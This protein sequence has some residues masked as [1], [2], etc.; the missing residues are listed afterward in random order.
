MS[1]KLAKKM[2]R[3]TLDIFVAITRKKS[4]K[5]IEEKR[6]MKIKNEIHEKEKEENRKLT[7]QEKKAI[8]KSTKLTSSERNVIIKNVAKKTR[9]IAAVAGLFGMGILSGVTGTKLLN[10]ANDKGVQIEKSDEGKEVKI[11]L[12]EVDKVT[13]KGL[14]DNEK[15]NQGSVYVEK[16]ENSFLQSIKVEANE[17]SGNENLYESAKEEVEQLKNSDEVLKYMKKLYVERYNERNGTNIT[18]KNVE[19]F[20]GRGD[21]I[22]VD[23]AKN[24]DEIV[25]TN[26]S[27][28]YEGDNYQLYSQIGI[29]SATIRDDNGNFV[30]KE[31]MTYNNGKYV[32]VYDKDEVVEANTGNTL[33]DL[34]GITFNGIDYY[35]AFVDDEKEIYED[36][37]IDSVKEY[38]KEKINKILNNNYQ[39]TND[40][41]QTKSEDEETR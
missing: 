27:T 31:K 20:K 33:T 29:V 36:R 7:K 1:N 17:V 28:K 19:L 5:K 10:P 15:D 9:K 40:T 18:E 24:G 6:Q 25:R 21:T 11:D 37:L 12:N 16:E 38:K 26:G 34:K 4:S 30:K 35:S 23:T 39:Y 32:Q 8:S 2:D 14:E 41:Y 22:Y 13:I 3:K